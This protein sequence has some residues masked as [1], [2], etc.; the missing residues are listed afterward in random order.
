MARRDEEYTHKTSV[1]ESCSG[2]WCCWGCWDSKFAGASSI[3]GGRFTVERE[4]ERK[5][6]DNTRNQG[7]LGLVVQESFFM[8]AKVLFFLPYLL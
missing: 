1:S 5:V 6:S 3:A 7:S 8:K 2:C 4:R